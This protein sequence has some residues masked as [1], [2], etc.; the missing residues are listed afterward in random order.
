MVL[1]EPIV[2]AIIGLIER[3]LKNFSWLWN[4]KLSHFWS[5][6]VMFFDGWLLLLDCIV[7]NILIKILWVGYHNSW[8]ICIPYS[9]SLI[10][11]HL[12]RQ[13]QIRITFLIWGNSQL[14]WLTP[15]FWER[16]DRL[17]LIEIGP[18]LFVSASHRSLGQQTESIFTSGRLNVFNLIDLTFKSQDLS[19]AIFYLVHESA[20]FLKL[21]LL[22]LN[23]FLLFNLDLILQWTHIF[24][25]FLL[26][27]IMLYRQFRK[28]AP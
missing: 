9:G 11:L 19:V 17:V 6:L 4:D 23:P 22:C 14:W 15:K 5:C 20:P 10:R 16:R 26:Q 25:I 7:D 27:I 2:L 24:W 18:T 12:L 1:N 28:L 21:I 3:V 13:K 8:L